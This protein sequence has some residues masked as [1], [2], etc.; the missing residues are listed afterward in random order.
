MLACVSALDVPSNLWPTAAAAKNTAARP[1]LLWKWTQLTR[2][3]RDLMLYFLCPGDGSEACE[4]GEKILAC[5]HH[6]ELLSPRQPRNEGTFCG[7]FFPVF[8]PSLLVLFIMP[9]PLTFWIDWIFFPPRRR[10]SWL[11]SLHVKKSSILK[12]RAKRRRRRRRF[13]V[14]H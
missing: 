12:T 5:R 1:Q 11:N 7:L 8:I 3:C 10:G 14:G 4:L 9:V 6:Q 2:M 13:Y